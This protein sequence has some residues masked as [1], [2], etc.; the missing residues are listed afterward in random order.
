MMLGL[1]P[2]KGES[3]ATRTYDKMQIAVSSLTGKQSY[4]W[5]L[6]HEI[7]EAKFSNEVLG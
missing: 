2:M 5:L 1:V 3:I 6:R 4:I 7:W